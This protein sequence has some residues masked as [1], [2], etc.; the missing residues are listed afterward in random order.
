[1]H[2]AIV[3]LFIQTV[4]DRLVVYMQAVPQEVYPLLVASLVLVIE[5]KGMVWMSMTLF[6]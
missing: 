1:M 4:K 5:W 6:S 2:P 3:Q